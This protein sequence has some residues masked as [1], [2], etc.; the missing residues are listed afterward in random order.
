MKYV[1]KSAGNCYDTKLRY[2]EANMDDKKMVMLGMTI[3]SMIGG[4]IPT[5]LGADIFS[6]WGVVGTLVGGLIGIWAG[7]SLKNLF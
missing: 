6:L 3:G 1:E 5:L 7:F 4:F 2:Q